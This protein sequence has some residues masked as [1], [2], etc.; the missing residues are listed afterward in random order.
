MQAGRAATV[1]VWRLAFAGALYSP[2]ALPPCTI[3]ES[4]DGMEK[5]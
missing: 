4:E 1:D 3:F 5:A 2:T